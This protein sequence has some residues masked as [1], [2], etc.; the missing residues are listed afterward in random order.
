MF[1]IEK[2]QKEFREKAS[3]L[4]R[5]ETP[6]WSEFERD[7]SNSSNQDIQ[8]YKEYLYPNFS[9]IGAKLFNPH[10]DPK[11]FSNPFLGTYMVQLIIFKENTRRNRFV[12][13]LYRGRMKEA[14]HSYKTLQGAMN[15][16]DKLKEIAEEEYNNKYQNLF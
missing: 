13:Y 2:R 10:G 7:F 15:K 3:S 12:V 8:E 14:Y 6:I 11:Y 4:F 1:N 5:S 9:S 16:V